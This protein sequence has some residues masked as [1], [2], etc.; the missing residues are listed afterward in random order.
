[1]ELTD[2]TKAFLDKQLLLIMKLAKGRIIGNM[3]MIEDLA[4]ATYEELNQQALPHKKNNESRGA[5][6]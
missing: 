2:G 4:R 3:P 6:E 5:K 1:M